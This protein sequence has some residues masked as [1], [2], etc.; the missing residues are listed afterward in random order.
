MGEVRRIYKV[1]QY[2]IGDEKYKMYTDEVKIIA[3]R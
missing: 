1:S 3:I 2:K